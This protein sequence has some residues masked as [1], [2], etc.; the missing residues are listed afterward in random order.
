MNEPSPGRLHETLWR[1]GEKVSDKRIECM[2]SKQLVRVAVAGKFDPVHEGHIDHIVKAA[3]LGDYLYIITHED[4]VVAS[5]SGKGFCAVPLK[6]RL[7]ILEAIMR[8]HG[9]KGEV[10]VANSPD[11]TCANTL[12]RIR[13]NIFAKGGDRSAGN[14]PPNEIEVCDQIG[15]RIVYGAGDLLN[16]S[17]KIMA[18]ALKMVRPTW[19]LRKSNDQYEVWD[20]NRIGERT[21]SITYLKPHQKTNGNQHNYPELMVWLNG[22]AWLT[23]GNNCRILMIP[24]MEM[25]VEA[26]SFHRVENE[27]DETVSF[28]CVW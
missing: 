27:S 13:P 6:A 2:C 18:A 10:V 28:L 20:S 22:S 24:R 23:I 14:M 19:V 7:S 8:Y 17:S 4:H 15:C 1:Q 26:G 21:A 5:V 16:S 3:S 9:I 25:T 11:G 12:E